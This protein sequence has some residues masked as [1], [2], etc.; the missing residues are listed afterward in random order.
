MHDRLVAQVDAGLPWSTIKHEWGD[1]IKEMYFSQLL[2]QGCP[3]PKHRRTPHMVGTRFLL[4]D[5]PLIL[6]SMVEKVSALFGTPFMRAP[7]S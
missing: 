5:Y 1:R 4:E 3:R 7:Y 2:R 6:P